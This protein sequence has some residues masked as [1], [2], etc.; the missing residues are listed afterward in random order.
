MRSLRSGLTV[1]SPK[2]M[3]ATTCTETPSMRS[4]KQFGASLPMRAELMSRNRSLARDPAFQSADV[5]RANGCGFNVS[6]AWRVMANRPGRIVTYGARRREDNSVFHWRLLCCQVIPPER[7]ADSH[8][9]PGS[10]SSR[11]LSTQSTILRTSF[12]CVPA[13]TTPS[14]PGHVPSLLHAPHQV[15]TVAGANSELWR[16]VG[17]FPLP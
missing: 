12:C 15:V 3:P 14:L 10:T 7:S 11:V 1:V 5:E 6:S 2:S 4:W 13:C 17:S 16:E 9:G 8:A